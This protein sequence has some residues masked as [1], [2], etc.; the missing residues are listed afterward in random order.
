LTASETWWNP[1]KAMARRL[2]T[3]PVALTPCLLL[4]CVQ[5]PPPVDPT[6][7]IP[8]APSVSPAPPASPA[9]A[10]P[11]KASADAT[12]GLRPLAT[13][14][15]VLNSVE[16]G[17]PDP[18]GRLIA[19]LPVPLG[20]D[21]K[22]LS[23]A[24]IAAATAVMRGQGPAAGRAMPGRSGNASFA[25]LAPLEPPR[26]F[27]VSGVIL[28]GGASEAVVRYGSLSGSLRTGDRGGLS[29]DL[30]PP[31]WSVAAIDVQRG[32][33]TLQKDGQRVK[34]EI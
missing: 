14:Q 16:L 29:T 4:G 25:P 13:P 1:A 18:F 31:G 3:I 32:V 22:P 34:V 8:P 7:L 20:P 21:G 11:P 28:G 17:R 10:K 15:Q 24:A 9:A 12:A 6:V 23:A 27:S 26:N 19:A 5:T 30:L 33:L 2:L